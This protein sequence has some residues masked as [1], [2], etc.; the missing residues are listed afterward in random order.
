MWKLP[1]FNIP[2]HAHFVTTKT[3]G[4]RKIFNEAK[5]CGIVLGEIE[6]YQKYLGFEVAG[7]CLMP[8][9]LH[10]IVWWDVDSYPDLTISKIILAIK[11]HSARRIVDLINQSRRGPLTSPS[12]SLGQ[13]TQATRREYPHRRM[14]DQKYIIWQSSFY[15]FN[16][17][18]EKKLLEKLAYIHDNPRRAGLAVRALDYPYSSAR[19]YFFGDHSLVSVNTSLV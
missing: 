18:S 16:I 5:C 3:H 14:S 1:K 12:V 19:S 9:H 17:Y 2:G 7:Y 4:N 8:D 15:D 11:G 13:G 10:L 6:F